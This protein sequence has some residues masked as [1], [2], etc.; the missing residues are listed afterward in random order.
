MSKAAAVELLLKLV[1]NVVKSP[2]EQKQ[3]GIMRPKLVQ[4]HS[5]VRGI[6][7]HVFTVLL[8]PSTAWKRILSAMFKEARSSKCAC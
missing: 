6:M 5:I 3:L 2:D 8:A 7:M 4:L 1:R